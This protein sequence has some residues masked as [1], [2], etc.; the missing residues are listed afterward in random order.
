M[1]EAKKLEATMREH[2]ELLEQPPWIEVNQ[3]EEKCSN[4]KDLAVE[5]QHEGCEEAEVGGKNKSRHCVF[6]NK[7]SKLE[8]KFCKAAIFEA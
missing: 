8:D 3:R 2:Y 1:Q 6:A 5:G 7:G 4:G